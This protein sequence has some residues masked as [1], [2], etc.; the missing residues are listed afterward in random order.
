MEKSDLNSRIGRNLAV[1]LDRRQL[2]RK[3]FA[4]SIGIDDGQ[5]RHLISGK[6]RWNATNLEKIAEGL[7]IGPEELINPSCKRPAPMPILKI[8]KVERFRKFEQQAPL[9]ENH[10][11]PIR[12]LGDKVAASVPMEID[13]D[14]V[15]GWALI[16][17]SKEW[18]PHDPENYTCAHITGDSMLP[19]LA[20]G[21][22]VAIDHAERDP[23]FL[24]NKMVAFQDNGGVTV[25][26]LRYYPEKQLAVGDPENPAR[27]DTR[28]VLLG[29]EINRGIVGKIA[30]WWAKR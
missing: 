8:E 19:V 3:P 2:K 13:E 4:K 16:Y 15:E 17:D 11:I 10:Y 12:L 28:V 14:D 30:W 21:D 27:I 29:E 9:T 5:L 1:E 23:E 22:I 24:N 20:P 7:G 25:K 26:W 6:A 18:L